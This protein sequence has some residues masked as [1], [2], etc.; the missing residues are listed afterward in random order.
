MQDADYG[1]VVSISTNGNEAFSA[2]KVRDP[3][4]TSADMVL[5]YFASRT[6]S[7]DSES[8]ATMPTAFTA[9]LLDHVAL[10]EIML[11][12][13]RT[14]S[15]TVEVEAPHA[16]VGVRCLAQYP[17]D[18][19]RSKS[20]IAFRKDDGQTTG[21]L[22]EL[23]KL[24]RNVTD[25]EIA[26]WTAYLD[27]S[28]FEAALKLGPVL[29]PVYIPS[30]EPRSR[31]TI[32]LI[33]YGEVQNKSTI[34]PEQTEYLPWVLDQL[35]LE[36]SNLSFYAKVCTISAYWNVGAVSLST[37]DSQRGVVATRSSSV[38]ARADSEQLTLDFAGAHTLRSAAFTRFLIK[39][40]GTP[41]TVSVA[42]SRFLAY[43]L[44]RIPL[45]DNVENTSFVLEPRPSGFRPYNITTVL[46]GYGYGTRS[47]SIYLAMTVIITYCAI[48]ISY[49]LYSIITGSVSTAWNSGIE[50]FTLALQSRKPDHLGHTSVG[51]D[52]IK[53][54]KEGVGIRVNRDNELEIVFAN[55]RDFRTRDLR[56]INK[57]RE[58]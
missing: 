21:E 18:N 9:R 15:V 48:T 16:V 31:S 24:L 37:K 51:V 19:I 38:S 32:A 42:L 23:R 29:G 12:D 58:Y 10:D 7:A 55:D 39:E 52:S 4:M 47:T 17:L 44:A 45:S 11:G 41:Y 33:V 22:P 25:V 14:R 35:Q 6:G 56:K 13:R 1:G 28:R 57:N 27:W 3:E 2:S 54:F 36:K 40:P 46:W 53:T 5:R 34:P 30:P 8:N 26:Q 50:L 43:R 49:M 20:K